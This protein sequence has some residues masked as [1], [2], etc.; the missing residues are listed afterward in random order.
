MLYLTVEKFLHISLF[1]GRMGSDLEEKIGKKRRFGRVLG[2]MLN[3]SEDASESFDA[4]ARGRVSPGFV[5]QILESSM[6]ARNARRN[7]FAAVILF[8]AALIATS[9]FVAG[10]GIPKTFGELVPDAVVKTAVEEWTDRADSP[11]DGRYAVFEKFVCPHYLDGRDL[12]QKNG[13][14]GDPCWKLLYAAYSGGEWYFGHDFP[15]R[16]S[17]VKQ[18]E[19]SGTRDV[20]MEI[21]RKYLRDPARLRAFYEGKKAVALE[22]IRAL[23]AEKRQEFIKTVA[24]FVGGMKLSRNPVIFTLATTV[25]VAEKHLAFADWK[26][27]EKWAAVHDAEADLRTALGDEAWL[28]DGG[29]RFALRRWDESGDALRDAWIGIGED[30][31]AALKE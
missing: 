18:Q 30:F 17:L 27:D 29:V 26:G 21:A 20:I 28:K 5:S 13:D 14:D 12:V 6:N 4:G 24:G 22:A 23:P 31:L 3:K 16:F 25:L 10:T 9:F 2:F 11:A 7:L 15:G 19:I 1:F 8:A